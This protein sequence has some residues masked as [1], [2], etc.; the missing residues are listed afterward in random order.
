MQYRL[1]LA[2]LAASATTVLAAP[3]SADAK[4]AQY[5]GYGMLL[6]CSLTALRSL[7]L[8]GTYSGYGTYPD[9]PPSTYTTYAPPP[10]G[11]GSYKAKERR[12][13]ADAKVAQYDGYGMILS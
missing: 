8:I 11:Y 13:A 9:Q 4:V 10:N 5:D 2:L 12:D 3:V 7:Q 6:P 1:T